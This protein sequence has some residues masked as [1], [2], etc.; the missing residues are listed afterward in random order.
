MTKFGAVVS[1]RILDLA[2]SIDV[3][4]DGTNAT[5][6]SEQFT[7]QNAAVLSGKLWPVVYQRSHVGAPI[8][9]PMRSLRDVEFSEKLSSSWSVQREISVPIVNRASD[10][11]IIV[12]LAGVK[13]RIPQGHDALV[14]ESDHTAN[15][16]IDAVH[17]GVSPGFALASSAK[18]LS[19]RGP[20]LRLYGRIDDPAEAPK[21]WAHL[22]NFLENENFPWRAKICSI[23]SL[24]PRNDAVVVYLPRAGWRRAQSCADVLQV[25]AA[26]GVQTSPFTRPLTAG[27]SCA[28]EPSDARPAY[29]RLSFGQH[30]A[31]I[32]T[33][34]VVE[35][36]S[37][38]SSM[39]D[40]DLATTLQ[41][42]C[43]AGEIDTYDFSRNL[44]SPMIDIIGAGWL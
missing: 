17:R 43:I 26:L 4:A 40:A 8:S 38:N 5:F 29:Q 41:T 11:S 21:I 33:E 32:C 36:A 14:G 27:V 34:A 44:S 22:L 7:A 18:P 30:R 39:D 15:I 3:S 19:N 9:T 1:D 20:L 24:Y 10:K 6:L 13:W 37:T 31:R 35:H 12:D 2:K 16:A 42:H 28:F 25:T 23:R